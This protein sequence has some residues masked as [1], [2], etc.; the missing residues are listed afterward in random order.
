L[1]PTGKE[2]VICLEIAEGY[3]KLASALA[4]KSGAS[5]VAILPIPQ[6][7]NARNSTRKIAPAREA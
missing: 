7:V 4:A 3:A 2:A 5:A 1:L 6:A